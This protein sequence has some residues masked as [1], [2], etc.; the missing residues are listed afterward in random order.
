MCMP[1]GL[2]C[3]PMEVDGARFGARIQIPCRVR[4]PA[5]FQS[6]KNLFS[7]PVVAA[8]PTARVADADVQALKSRGNELLAQGKTAE[9]TEQY[10]RASEFAPLDAALHVNVGYGLLELDDLPGRWMPTLWM[11]TFFLAKCWRDR[12]CQRRRCKA[13]GRRWF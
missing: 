8:P 1:N 3:R 13:S 5:I 11:P 9:A 4:E 7:R 10:K 12:V 6:V 2:R